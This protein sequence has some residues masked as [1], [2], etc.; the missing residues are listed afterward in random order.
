MKPLLIFA[1]AFLGI[2]HQSFSQSDSIVSGKNDSNILPSLRYIVYLENPND[3]NFNKPIDLELFNLFN[4]SLK[5]IKD[6]NFTISNFNLKKK[7]LFDYQDF[8]NKPADRLKEL[9]PNYDLM[10]APLP[11][12]PLF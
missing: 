3:Q 1:L 9:M 6:G 11:S 4:Y 5:S 8:K 7:N 10:S 2:V 12:Q